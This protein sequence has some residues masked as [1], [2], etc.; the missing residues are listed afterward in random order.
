MVAHLALDLHSFAH[1]RQILET[2]GQDVCGYTAV[3][4]VNKREI[5]IQ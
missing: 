3:K 2:L 4:C 5:H 1:L